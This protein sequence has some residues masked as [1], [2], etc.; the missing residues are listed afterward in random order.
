[1]STPGEVRASGVDRQRL[2]LGRLRYF[3][4]SVEKKMA[5]RPLYLRQNGPEVN[6]LLVII[7]A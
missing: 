2:A 6:V 7:R 3:V 1:M 4:N 5:A